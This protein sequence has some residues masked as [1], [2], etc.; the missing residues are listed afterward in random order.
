MP[1][2][3]RSCRSAGFGRSC[4]EA[5]IHGALGFGWVRGVLP[6]AL[7]MAAPGARLRARLDGPPA[8]PSATGTLKATTGWVSPFKMSASISFLGGTVPFRWKVDENG[9]LIEVPEQQTV[10]RQIGELRR[11]GPSLR[12]IAARIR[13]AVSHVTV[14]GILSNADAESENEPLS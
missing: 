1:R 4:T 11:E 13:G 14:K 2:S 10:I 3:G 7:R 6:F 8:S 5:A 9:A 12:S